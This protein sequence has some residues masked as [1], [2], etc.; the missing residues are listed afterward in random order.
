MVNHPGGILPSRMIPNEDKFMRYLLPENL[1]ILLCAT[2]GFVVGAIRY[3]RPKKPLYA[4]MIVLGLGCVLL[5]RLYQCVRLLTGS[6][7]TEHFQIGVLGAA[8]A[9]SFFFSLSINQV[10][11]I[12][13]SILSFFYSIISLSVS[14]LVSPSLYNQS[15][16]FSS[17]LFPPFTLILTIYITLSTF[18][19]IK[20]VSLLTLLSFDLLSSLLS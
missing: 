4:S 18:L 10:V 16:G 3:L 7:L 2:V 15:E 17:L 19:L 8:G 5:G 12:L 11:C 9:F 20:S 14:P 1:G 13:S 6:A